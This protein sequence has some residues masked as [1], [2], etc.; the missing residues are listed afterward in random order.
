[1]IQTKRKL[2]DIVKEDLNSLE[3]KIGFKITELRIDP[4]IIIKPINKVNE[5][6]NDKEFNT[7]LK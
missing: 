6:S 7:K 1:M 3:Y 2:I 4:I 5:F